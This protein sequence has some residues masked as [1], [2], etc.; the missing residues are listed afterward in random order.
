MNA[1]QTKGETKMA[2]MLTN[3]KFTAAVKNAAVGRSKA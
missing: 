3:V 1:K 2:K